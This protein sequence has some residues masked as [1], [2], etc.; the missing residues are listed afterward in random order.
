VTFAA[1]DTEE[2]V[3]VQVVGDTIDEPNE[4]FVVNLSA[5]SGATIS[6]TQ[7]TGTILDDDAAAGA[8]PDTAT[9]GPSGLQDGLRLLVL[10]AAPATALVASRR[11]SAPRRTS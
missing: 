11:R 6:D 10:L 1:G 9:G 4:T 8:L 5:A 2:T 7:G 3:T